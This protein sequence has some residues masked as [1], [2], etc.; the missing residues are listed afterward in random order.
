MSLAPGSRVGPYEVTA[1]IGRGGM[2]EVYRARDTRLHRDVALKVLPNGEWL[3]Y[4]ANRRGRGEVYVRRFP[5]E[6]SDVPLTT[7]G[8]SNPVW[9]RDGSELYYWTVQDGTVTI[10]AVRA[11]SGPPSAW[12]RAEPVIS[13]PFIESQ[14]DTQYDVAPDG[15]F[16]VLKKASGSRP[17]DGI[18][19]IQNW[20][21]ELKRLVPVDGDRS[22]A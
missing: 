21:E 1:Q 11:T 20:T 7:D 12:G 22:G 5:V 13:G 18:L 10:M 17:A 15:R 9:A 14:G 3:A 2:G 6:G 8:G 19:I 16:L 4:Q